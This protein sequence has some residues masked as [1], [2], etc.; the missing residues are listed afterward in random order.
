MLN[1]TA[2]CKKFAPCLWQAAFVILLS[3]IS[4]T[5][6]HCVGS[7]PAFILLLPGF[8]PVRVAYA[9]MFLP[10]AINLSNFLLA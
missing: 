7:T 10:Q 2:F 8:S 3:P 4:C 9:I 5:L 1:I 6:T